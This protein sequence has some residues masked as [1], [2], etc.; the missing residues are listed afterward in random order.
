MNAQIL[1]LQLP[2]AQHK[3]PLSQF[4]WVVPS[5][6]CML[7]FSQTL[8][9]TYEKKS[10]KIFQCYVTKR[11]YQQYNYSHISKFIYL[12][13]KYS[14][15]MCHITQSI[16]GKAP[17]YQNH[18][19]KDQ[20]LLENQDQRCTPFGHSRHFHAFQKVCMMHTYQRILRKLKIV[21]LHIKHC[22]SDPYI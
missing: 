3:K 12:S 21:N 20:I 18:H 8:H 19:T 10:F 14:D 15:M 7:S 13:C 1:P 22:N 2:S 6:L 11:T 9:P 4:P 17:K 5:P 16:W